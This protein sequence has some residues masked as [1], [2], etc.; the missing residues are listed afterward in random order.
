MGLDNGIIVKKNGTTIEMY[1]NKSRYITYEWD[2]DFEVAYWRKCWNVRADI[3]WLTNGWRH[4]QSYT[5][6]DKDDIYHII[7]LLKSYNK[8][9]WDKSETIWSWKEHK[10]I[11]KRHIRNLKYL[12]KYMKKHDDIEVRFYDSY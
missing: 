12:Y 3:L 4:D 5:V 6:L 1:K 10:K 8:N 7:K 2:T 9:T 11:N